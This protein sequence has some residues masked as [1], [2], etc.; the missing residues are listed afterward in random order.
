[1]APSAANTELWK[2]NKKRNPGLPTPLP[3]PPT[4]DD[5]RP[6]FLGTLRPLLII[7]PYH[8]G[9]KYHPGDNYHPDD[10]KSTTRVIGITRVLSVTRVIG[11]TRVVR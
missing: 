7:L 10:K 5:R 1:M 11:I 3:P 9:D 2:K 4:L 8:P 6:G